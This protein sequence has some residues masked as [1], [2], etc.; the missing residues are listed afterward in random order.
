MGFK[1]L[2]EKTNDCSGFAIDATDLN[3]DRIDDMVLSAVGWNSYDY[4]GHA[5]VVFGHRGMWP[6]AQ[7]YNQLNNED[8]FTLFGM[9]NEYCAGYISVGDINDDGIGDILV[10]A[11]YYA[12]KT[13]RAY[14]VFGKPFVPYCKRVL[15]ANTSRCAECDGGYEFDKARGSC[16]DCQWSNSYWASDVSKCRSCAQG[17]CLACT[18]N[19]T[20]TLCTFGFEPAGKML[21]CA[22]CANS[23]QWN[24]PAGSACVDCELNDKCLACSM[25]NGSCTLCPRGLRPNATGCVKYTLTVDQII[26]FVVVGMTVVAIVAVVITC[27]VFRK[28]S[29]RVIIVK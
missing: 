25:S 28:R 19:G 22:A 4:V 2:G 13:G 6:A 21:Q 9:E 27:L 3:G 15:A 26:T 18:G 24:S 1:L 5:Y 10:G 23:T 14:L 20:C 12:T 17:D 29:K 16:S 7:T 8:S 11:A